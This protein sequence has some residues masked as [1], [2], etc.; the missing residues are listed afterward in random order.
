MSEVALGTMSQVRL[1]LQ[2]LAVLALAQ[3]LSSHPEIPLL[4]KECQTSYGEVWPRKTC[5]SLEQMRKWL[6]RGCQWQG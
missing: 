1:E 3:G 2:G 4:F 5:S 6:S